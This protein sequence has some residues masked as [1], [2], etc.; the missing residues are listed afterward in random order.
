M[1]SK[2]EKAQN[3]AEAIAY[4][5]GILKPG[6][7][8][9]CTV[10]HVSASGMSRSI[11]LQVPV[12][13]SDGALRI[14]DIS[15][16]AADAIGERFDDRRGGVIMGGCG[17]NMCFAAVYDLGRVLFPGGFGT[18]G[19]HPDKPGKYRRP[20]GKAQAARMVRDGWRFHGRNSDADGWDNDGGYA[21]D[22]RG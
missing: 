7:R 4:L 6:A 11:M 5:R 9:T 18:I 20:K 17:M 15:W 21:L 2:K 8:I 13:D 3:R 1:T 10:L 14:Q 19:T 22:Y 16:R 12:T